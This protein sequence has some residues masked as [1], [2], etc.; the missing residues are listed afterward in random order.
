MC[1][2]CSRTLLLLNS[3]VLMI[4]LMIVMVIHQLLLIFLLCKYLPGANSAY[5]DD[6]THLALTF[7]ESS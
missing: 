6:K 1:F 3:E 5:G 7:M 2:L 4:G